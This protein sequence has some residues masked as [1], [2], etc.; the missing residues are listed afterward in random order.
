MQCFVGICGVVRG[1]EVLVVIC[2]VL[3]WYVVFCGDMWI[4]GIVRGY[5]VLVVI[6]SV[7]LWYVVFCGDM[8]MCCFVQ[9]YAVLCGNM[10]CF[11]V[12]R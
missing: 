7:L 11:A 4:C 3:L 6:C 2:S 8:W 10:R 1:Y 9:G 12:I 5:D